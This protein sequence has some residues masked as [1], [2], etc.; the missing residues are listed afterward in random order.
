MKNSIKGKKILIT[1]ITGFVG[2]NLAK[3]LSTLGASVYGISRSVENKRIKKLNILHYKSIQGL[4]EQLNVNICIH[5]AADSLVEKGQKKPYEVFTTN[6]QGTLNILESSRINKVEKIII[7]STSH[8]YGKNKV[9]YFERYAARPSRPYETSKT[10]TDLIAQSYAETYK[11]PVL[12]PRFVNIY[13]PGDLNFGRLIPRTIKSV[14]LEK[15]PKMWGGD[16]LRDYLY[17]DDAIDAYI[18]LIN[19]P[20]DKVKQNF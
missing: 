2:S 20:K 7:A 19:L 6:I 15:S 9:P 5:L 1:G 16:A 14:L 18:A 4:I 8:V 17:I 12:I 13:G 3:R 11:L 10:C